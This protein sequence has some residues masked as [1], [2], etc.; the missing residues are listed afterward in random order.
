MN[1]AT[2]ETGTSAVTPGTELTTVEYRSRTRT[3]QRGGR[4]RGQWSHV[5]KR[6]DTRT[7]HTMPLAATAG[8]TAGDN[9]VTRQPRSNT[10]QGEYSSND[11]PTGTGMGDR[12]NTN[13]VAARAVRARPRSK[14]GRPAGAGHPDPDP[15]P[16]RDR[17]QPGAGRP[18]EANRSDTPKICGTRPG[19]SRTRRSKP[20]AIRGRTGIQCDLTTS[21]DRGKDSRTETNCRGESGRRRPTATDTTAPQDRSGEATA[22]LHWDWQAPSDPGQRERP[23]TSG[24]DRSQDFDSGDESDPSAT[25][26]PRERDHEQPALLWSTINEWSDI[27]D[28]DNIHQLRQ[29]TDWRNYALGARSGDLPFPLPP[30]KSTLLEPGQDHPARRHHADPPFPHDAATGT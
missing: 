25:A 10:V 20:Q 11:L 14:A 15:D 21:T 5:T 9:S 18:R 2:P 23:T 24:N 13:T 7:E 27:T 12:V 6:A 3:V 28:N 1:G 4:C 8:T 22:A 17:P 29:P 19:S 30:T 26:G 16:S